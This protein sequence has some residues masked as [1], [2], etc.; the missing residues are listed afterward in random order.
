MLKI[1][2]IIITKNRPLKLIR[3]VQSII[4]NSLAPSELIIVDSSDTSETDLIINKMSNR[5]PFPFIYKRIHAKGIAKPLNTAILL[6]S[7]NII[8]KIDDD[9]YADKHWIKII[10]QTYTSFPKAMAIT[11]SVIP[12]DMNNYWQ[13]VWYEILRNSYTY[14]GQTY[15]IY[16]SNAAY[17]REVFSKYKL[18]INEK[19]K[20]IA[21]E[22]SYISFMLNQKKLLI[23]HN[24]E[25][26]VFHDFRNTM[27]SFVRQWFNYGMADYQLWKLYP[28]ISANLS[29]L[30]PI[31]FRS[32]FSIARAQTRNWTKT[33]KYIFIPG[34]IIRNASY[35]FGALYEFITNKHEA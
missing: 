34:F 11:G 33:Q 5:I 23:I 31:S 26:K 25:M 13:K 7:G 28:E 22:D 15:S 18:F 3:T 32:I 24:F 2:V 19:N 29:K 16:G 21:A 17:R 6:A 9:E 27:L 4:H 12:T 10:Q 35:I 8:A 1:S 20:G 30:K 14:T